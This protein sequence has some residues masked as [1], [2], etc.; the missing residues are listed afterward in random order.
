MAVMSTAPFVS[1]PR[2]TTRARR[3]PNTQADPCEFPDLQS[4]ISIDHEA[5]Y[6]AVFVRSAESTI[7]LQQRAP[8]F[9]D[10][11]AESQ[12]NL[13]DEA[14]RLRC[15]PADAETDLDLFHSVTVAGGRIEAS[16][17]RCVDQVS[18]GFSVEDWIILDQ[19][20]LEW[21]EA[22]D[23]GGDIE[24]DAVAM[25]VSVE[26]PDRFCYK[27]IGPICELVGPLTPGTTYYVQTDGSGTVTETEPA[28]V[29][30]PRLFAISSTEAILLPYRP[31]DP[32]TTGGAKQV[33]IFD[34]DAAIA[35]S[36]QVTLGAIP[37]AGSEEVYLNGQNLIRGATRDYT[38]TGAVITIITTPTPRPLKVGDVIKVTYDT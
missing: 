11:T 15:I 24:S 36:K 28:G 14:D 4:N 27:P 25:V 5:E 31:L 37:I 38:I 20:S 34:V 17:T 21:T 16:V 22:F 30:V 8:A 12:I 3:P 6:T 10:L 1:C 35:T 2:G 13:T 33:E 7:N 18:H 19:T 26:G 9:W 23:P 32:A 29:S